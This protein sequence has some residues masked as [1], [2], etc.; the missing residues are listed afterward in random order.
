MK[1][2]VKLF[3]SSTCPNCPAAEKEI[4]EIKE[5]RDDFE[6]KIFDTMT[7]MGAREAIQENIRSVPTYIIKGDGFENKI[8]LI[9]SQGHDTLNKY[10]D[11]SLGLKKIDEKKSFWQK[12][13]D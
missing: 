8:G 6:L 12:I 10:I 5:K 11:V 3:V 4:H 9:G 13:F 7:S 1:T 2:L